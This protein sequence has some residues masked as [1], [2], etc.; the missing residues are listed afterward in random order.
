MQRLKKALTK[1]EAEAL[2]AQLEEA[3]ASVEIQ[4]IIT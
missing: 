1:E 3:G 2:K 4:V